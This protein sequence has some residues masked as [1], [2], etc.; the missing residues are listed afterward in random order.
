MD[1]EYEGTRNQF[2]QEF[3]GYPVRGIG[4]ANIALIAII[5]IVI[6]AIVVII[7]FYLT[8]TTPTYIDRDAFFNLD[9]LQD[10]NNVNVEC[11]VFAGEVAPNEQ[12]VYD[13]ITD[14]T[15]SREPPVNINTVCASFP[16]TAA[17]I[18][19]NT[20]SEGNIIPIATFKAQPYY[21]FESG[22]FIICD[23]TTACT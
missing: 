16:D 13:T 5:I 11:C 22:L 18:S 8:R 1:Y 15:Y 23:S 20:D 7:A 3:G 19:Q 4:V 17:C 14:I 6:I 10:L 12:Y 2:F 9:L 21:T